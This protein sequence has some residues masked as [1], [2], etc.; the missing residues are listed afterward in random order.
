M[1]IKAYTGI[2]KM[3]LIAGMQYRAAAWAGVATQFFWGATELLVYSAFYR[4]SAVGAQPMPFGQLADLIWLRQAFLAMVMLWTQD[5]ELLDIVVNGHVA[6]EYCRPYRLYSFWFARLLAVRISN[7]ALR[8][9]P[10]L[11]V[12][13]FLPEPYRFH[14]PGSLAAFGLFLPAMVLALFL[15][16]AVSMF[17]YLLSM[18]TLNARGP[19]LLVGAMSEFF[20]GALI[21]IPLMPLWLQRVMDWLP[22]RYMADFPFRVY[23]G[24]IPVGQA[25]W[26]LVVQALWLVPL[27]GLGAFCFGRMQ[28]KVVIQGG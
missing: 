14:L 1:K 17:I 12:A 23:S 10:I 19:R 6:Y 5:N 16:V 21:P 27:V 24:N 9:L 8:C 7:T 13:F 15:V 26:G 20:M 18:V 11:V 25:A 4:S 28:R 3:R 2:F 22:F